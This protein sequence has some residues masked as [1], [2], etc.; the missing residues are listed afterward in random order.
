MKDEKK[1]KAQL[2]ADIAELRRE[3]ADLKA[4]A[5][6]R[7]PPKSKSYENAEQLK[8][9]TDTIQDAVIM[10][11][12]DGKFSFWNP[13]AEKIFGYTKQEAIGRGFLFIFPEEKRKFYREAFLQFLDTGW[14]YG[15]GEMR[16]YESIR[17]DGKRF[18]LEI[19]ASVV[20]LEGH[21]QIVGIGRD[22]TKRKRIEAE[23]TTYSG[24]LE[25]RVEERT[26]KLKKANE[27]LQQEIVERK[28]AEEALR[29]QRDLAVAF[30]SA[31]DLVQSLKETLKIITQ[32]C[33]MDCGG[34]YLVEPRTGEL[35]LVA[36]QGVKPAFLENASHFAADSSQAR[37][38]MQGQPVY[39]HYSK[40]VP[41]L[42]DPDQR[43]GLRSTAII[44]VKH[45]GRVVAAL[46]LASHTS[47]EIPFS[48]AHTL[49]IIAAQ[50]GGGIARLHA[51]TALRESE[52]RFR[53]LVDL[54]PQTVYEMDLEDN[55]TFVNRFGLDF[56]GYTQEDVDK[57][58]K[59][60]QI[61]APEDRERV[62]NN[63]HRIVAQELST[64]N[65][66][67]SLKKDGTVKSVIIYS[68][69]IIREGTPVGYFPVKQPVQK[70]SGLLT[71]A[72]SP[73]RLRYP[74]LSAPIKRRISWI[75]LV[76][77]MS[78]SREG[79]SMPKKQGNL[80]G[81]HDIRMWTS[82]APAVRRVETR[83]RLVVPRTMESSTTTTRFPWTTP[84][85][86]ES[87]MSTLLLLSSA[88]GMMNVRPM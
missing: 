5:K 70:F 32:I 42:S 40:M 69:P 23:L 15:F 4:S 80:M 22:I 79:K 75:S 38:V 65:E 12:E 76:E 6:K 71:E 85:R 39:R 16:E 87:F 86:T 84:E 26:A 68:S 44:P 2:I 55:F 1:T 47:D 60:S 24:H 58:I 7:K 48:T 19:F 41:D 20:T 30:S 13:A 34:V 64:G 35:N 27:Q 54:L 25:E 14:Q 37:L 31:P 10:M 45:E 28:R 33:E 17:K 36:H 78:S 49:E 51:E 74:R 82:V 52:Q 81:G 21:R 57:G 9:I 67:K 46:N 59:A 77:A 11:D 43:E 8:M 3:I 88:T 63:I 62:Q 53:E 29:V 50:I 73:S 72:R 56:Y 66:Y 83:R 61:I 18:P